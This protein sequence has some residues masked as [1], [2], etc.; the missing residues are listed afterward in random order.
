MGHRPGITVGTPVVQGQLIGWLGDSGNAE[1]TAPHLHFEIRTNA[2]AI[3]SYEYLLAAPVLTEAGD[4]GSWQGR[5][6]DDDDSVHQANIEILFAEGITKGCNPPTND[7]YCPSDA[8]TR[9]Q[10]T[11]FLRRHLELVAVGAD[12]YSDDAT[13]V[14]EEDINALTAAGIAFGCTQTAFCPN[15]DLTRAEMAE[16]LVRTFGY[17]DPEGGDY[18]GDDE[19]NVYEDAINVL[20][21]N[22]I[23]VGCT[24]TEYCPDESLTRGQMATFLAR[25]LG[26][27]S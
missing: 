5:F 16:F 2:V 10:V 7:M 23:T 9:G 6:R 11:A 22:G 25:A 18:F 15:V 4:P 19:G 13:S 26:L 24:P 1:E 20:Y 8:L 17:E 12:Y 27:G 14:F 21:A 3:N